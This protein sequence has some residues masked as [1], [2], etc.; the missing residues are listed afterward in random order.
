MRR[1]SGLHF[2][3]E[4]VM[5]QQQVEAFVESLPNV[6]SSEAY[7]YRFYFFGD[8]HRMPFL[9]IANSDNEYDNRSNLNREG[10]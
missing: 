7:G 5:N 1:L 3:V 2:Q 6:Q 4:S 10:V 8:D 9:T